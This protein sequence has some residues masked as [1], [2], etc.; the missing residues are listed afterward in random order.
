[1]CEAHLRNT[2][3]GI[4][5]IFTSYALSYTFDNVHNEISETKIFTWTFL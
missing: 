5:V 1:M 3:T 2:S 4:S